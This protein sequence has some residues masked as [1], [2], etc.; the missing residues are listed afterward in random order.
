MMLAKF[1]RLIAAGGV[2]A[3]AACASTSDRGPSGPVVIGEEDAGPIDPRAVPPDGRE[4]ARYDERRFVN[5]LHLQNSEPVRVGLL[6]PFTGATEAVQQVA[7]S[8][9]DAA[10]L[11]AFEAGEAFSATDAPPSWSRG[12]VI[13]VGGAIG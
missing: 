1:G 5:P 7:S 11:A 2:L 13:K 12:V 10:Q 6:L 3:L 4:R 9:F 8:M